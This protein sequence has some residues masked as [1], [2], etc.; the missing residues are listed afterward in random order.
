MLDNNELIEYIS[1]MKF[2]G[3]IKGIRDE[4][5]IFSNEPFTD[6]APFIPGKILEIPILNLLNYW[7]LTTIMTAKIVQSARS[8]E[9]FFLEHGE[10]QF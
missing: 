10:W 5:T 9:R 7:T 6:K 8:E 2:T 4:K 3:L 1:N